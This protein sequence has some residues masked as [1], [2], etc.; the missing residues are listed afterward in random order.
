MAGN[1][2]LLGDQT[3]IFWNSISVKDIDKSSKAIRRGKPVIK[4]ERAEFISL[5]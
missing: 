2:K 1:N 5:F 3:V 4:R